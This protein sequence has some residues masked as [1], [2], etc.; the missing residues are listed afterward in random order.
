M[1]SN[2]SL[3]TILAES[4]ALRPL[5]RGAGGAALWEYA[6]LTGSIALVAMV[7]IDPVGGE[8]SD[9]FNANEAD[10]AATTIGTGGGGGGGG[11]S[12]PPADPEC[13]DPGYSYAG[14]PFPFSV[15]SAYSGAPGQINSA[16]TPDVSQDDTEYCWDPAADNFMAITD[17]GGTNDTLYIVGASTDYEI[18]AGGD[19]FADQG[20]P[21]APTTVDSPDFFDLVVQNTN[22]T[23]GDVS[24]MREL[25]LRA[26][27]YFDTSYHIE[28][29]VFTVDNVE[30]TNIQP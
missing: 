29:I 3:K 24:T 30:I 11:G 27:D 12:T 26:Q 4:T 17:T 9:I 14:S 18:N 19:N 8:V 2:R 20:V 1:S 7:A 28:R 6:A 15:Y 23:P 10:I 21:G 16:D 5:Q 25:A 22:Y 13:G